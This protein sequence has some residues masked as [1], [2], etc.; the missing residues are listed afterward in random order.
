[1]MYNFEVMQEFENFRTR[2]QS[3][4]IKS[5]SFEIPEHSTMPNMGNKIATVTRL[6]PARI[7]SHRLKKCS[8]FF[9]FFFFISLTFFSLQ[10]TL[11][12]VPLFFLLRISP[13][14]WY[15]RFGSA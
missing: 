14:I 7:S 2:S 4:S 8:F 11:I 10:F 9:F 12:C 5:S 15:A 3:N 13:F 6:K 1:M